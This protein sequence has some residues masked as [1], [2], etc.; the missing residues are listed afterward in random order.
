MK[1]LLTWYGDDFTGS[2]AVMEV[3][4]F[5]GIDSVLFSAVPSNELRAR[6]GQARAIGIASTA[7]AQDP[8]WMDENL[9]EPFAFLHG[10]GAPILHYKV[11]STFDS[12][13]RSGNIGKAIEIGL[14]IRPSVAVPVLTAAPQQRRYQAFGHLFAG[15]FDGVHRLDRHPVMARHSYPCGP[16]RGTHPRPAPYLGQPRGRRWW[17]LGHHRPSTRA[18]AAAN[19]T[20]LCS[21][22]R[23]SGAAAESADRL[24]AGE[25]PCTKALTNFYVV[26]F[27][28]R[29]YR[30][31][32]AFMNQATVI[33]ELKTRASALN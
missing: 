2:A 1:P 26:L 9:P 33:A 16:R 27:Y 18:R 24:C 28:R 25:R 6:F 8:V 10:L 21:S 11:C 23:W 14:T 17:R 3:L 15:S 5:A 7:R 4:A 13:A 20:A 31:R 32:I 22:C 29:C 30:G 19:H 12:S